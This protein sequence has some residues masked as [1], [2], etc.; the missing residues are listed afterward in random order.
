MKA[1]FRIVESGYTKDFHVIYKI[2]CYEKREM[3]HNSFKSMNVPDMKRF[4]LGTINK[5]GNKQYILTD[6]TGD[7]ILEEIYKFY[8]YDMMAYVF[9]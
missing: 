8:T 1:F 4:N 2:Y 6:K 9:E 5:E 3:L 7:E